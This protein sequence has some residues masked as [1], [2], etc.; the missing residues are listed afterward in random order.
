MNPGSRMNSQFHSLRAGPY[1]HKRK[2]KPTCPQGRERADEIGWAQQDLPQSGAQLCWSQWAG[3][4]GLPSG[5]GGSH[6]HP[7]TDTGTGASPRK[8]RCCYGE[9]QTAIQTGKNNRIM[10]PGGNLHL[11]LCVP[12]DG[13][14]FTRKGQHCVIFESQHGGIQQN[15]PAV[16]KQCSRC[17]VCC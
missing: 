15:D 6:S 7:W 3:M 5:Q 1:L 4:R 14:S 11:C 2:N 13:S 12:P 9:T 10:Q 16:K 8:I 17:A